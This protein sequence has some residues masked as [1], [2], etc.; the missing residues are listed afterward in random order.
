[1]NKLHW[2]MTQSRP[3]IAVVVLLVV[4]G[5]ASSRDT[6][7]SIPHPLEGNWTY[8]VDSPQG[9]VSGTL[10][11]ADTEEGLSGEITSDAIG[12]DGAIALESVAFDGEAMQLVFSFDSGEYG[13]MEVTV[14]L[15]SDTLSGTWTAVDYGF[16]MP[17]VAS[18]KEE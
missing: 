6:A 10:A 12:A 15:E 9:V 2:I 1:M 16:D 14:T 4:V 17:V 3:L 5:C 18:R 11:F 8:T 7:T 13:V